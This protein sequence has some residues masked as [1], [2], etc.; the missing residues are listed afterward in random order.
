MQNLLKTASQWKNSI[1]TYS[2]FCKTSINLQPAK[3][4]LF[5]LI[6]E[7]AVHMNF[8]VNFV[9][10]FRTHFLYNIR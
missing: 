4:S 5:S 8:A 9:E 10:F 6:P 7:A 2:E 1:L 3:Q